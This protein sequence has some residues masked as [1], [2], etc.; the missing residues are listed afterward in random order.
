MQVNPNSTNSQGYQNPSSLPPQTGKRK[1]PGFEDREVQ[2]AHGVSEDS[3]KDVS[4][5]QRVENFHLIHS[6]KE[7]KKEKT[8]VLKREKHNFRE[9]CLFPHVL[10]YLSPRLPRIYHHIS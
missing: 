4:T 2:P 3:Q 6:L 10:R 1:N 9:N 5:T 8:L 7:L